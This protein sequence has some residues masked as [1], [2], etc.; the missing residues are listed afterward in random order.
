[1]RQ[2]RGLEA[3]MSGADA[4]APDVRAWSLA[5]GV[6]RI[7]FGVGM[8]A[9]PESALRTLGFAEVSPA[10]VA[11]TRLTGVRDLVLGLVTAA[12][13]DDR[14]RLRRA[15]VANALADTGDALAFGAAMRSPE[16]GA[17][18]RGLAAAVPA[19]AAGLWTAWRLS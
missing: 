4:T 11:V 15:T 16:R 2:S 19:A 5:S 14:D 10:T 18:V 13:L 1:V 8:L 3:L 12:A 9:A 17:A 6:G 7:A